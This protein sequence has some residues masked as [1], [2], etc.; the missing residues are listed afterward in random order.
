MERKQHHATQPNPILVPEEQ[1]VDSQLVQLQRI[2]GGGP[3]RKVNL[4]T[5]PTWLRYGGY[6]FLAL[7]IFFSLVCIIASAIR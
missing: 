2:E 3:P 4:Q 1:Y 5:F 6:G 7:M